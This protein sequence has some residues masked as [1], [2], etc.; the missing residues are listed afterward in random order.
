MPIW[1][2]FV[3]LFFPRVCAS[4]ANTLLRHEQ[5]ICQFC[6]HHLPATDFHRFRDN[7]VAKL[8]WGRAEVEAAAACF[9]FHKGSRVQHLVHGLKYK[10]LKETGIFLGRH[11]GRILQR[12]EDFSDV[13]YVVPVPLHVRK[14]RQRGYNQS[15]LFARGLA[16]SMGAVADTKTLVRISA[17]ET[18]TRKS[19]FLRWENVKEV[20]FLTD[21]Q[22]F[23]GKHVLLA[24]DVVTTGA[25]L[26]ACVHEIRKSGEVRV[27]IACIACA[28]K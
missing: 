21:P 12:C 5:C 10:G 28:L 9:Y 19:R 25:T 6:L 20:F 4:C 16:L 24:D 2:D 27:S 18:Q 8:F 14:K 23:R 3:S 7:P 22:M 13:D 11:Y 1:Y 17:T 15:E 26:E